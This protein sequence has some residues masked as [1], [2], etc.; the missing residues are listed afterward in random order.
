LSVDRKGLLVIHGSLSEPVQGAKETF[1]G[2][3]EGGKVRGPRVPP[4]SSCSA[5]EQLGPEQA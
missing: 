1:F 3:E 4:R 5:V 2:K